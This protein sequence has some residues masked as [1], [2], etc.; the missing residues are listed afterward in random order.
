MP[1]YSINLKSLSIKKIPRKRFNLTMAKL[2]FLVAVAI[3]YASASFKGKFILYTN[4]SYF[5]FEIYEYQTPIYRHVLD[6]TTVELFLLLRIRLHSFLKFRFLSKLALSTLKFLKFFPKESLIKI[7]SMEH[8]FLSAVNTLAPNPS[9]MH[10][11]MAMM[12]I[13]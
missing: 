7:S 3:A 11:L 9:I 8:F 13:I 10:F 2:F 12:F 1:E 5:I 6:Q 4:F